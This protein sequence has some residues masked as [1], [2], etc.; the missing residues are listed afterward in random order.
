MVPFAFVISAVC[1]LTCSRNAK[2]L[3]SWYETARR[4][5]VEKQI[6][7]RGVSDTSVINAMLKVDR[8]RFVPRE[9][10]KYAYADRPLPIGEAQTISQPYV[11]ALMTQELKLKKRERVLEIGTGSGYQAAILSVLAQD[12]YTIELIPVLAKSAAE[13]LESLGFENVQVK[14]GDGFLGWP[15]AGPFDAIIITCAVPRIPEPLVEQLAEGG[16]LIMPLGEELY[17]ELVLYRKKGDKLEET[18][19]IPVRFVPMKGKIRE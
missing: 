7:S 8:H 10:E 1:M 11:V 6:I 16:R 2:K 17:Q 15:E 9:Y 5:M 3:T 12:V 18:S 4:E 13:R 14:C 19:I